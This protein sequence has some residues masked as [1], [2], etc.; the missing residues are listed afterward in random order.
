LPKRPRTTV[1]KELRILIRSVQTIH[2]ALARLSP[3]LEA[4]PAARAPRSAGPAGA[5]RPLSAA[6]RAALKL[7]GQY[8]TYVRGLK[9]RPRA[10]VRKVAATSGV[11]AALALARQLARE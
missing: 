3:V 4:G 5:R 7:Q 11:R 10:R 2:D 9:P 8:M 6:R 1:R